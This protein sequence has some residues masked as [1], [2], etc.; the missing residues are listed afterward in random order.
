MLT[1]TSIEPASI[2]SHFT[3]KHGSDEHYIALSS[4][5][6]T[7]FQTDL[8]QL[9]TLYKKTLSER[10]LSEHTQIFSRLF[11]SDIANQTQALET[12]GL[13]KLLRKGACAIVQQKP[14]Q[15]GHVSLLSY[16][17]T[18][19]DK[20]PNKVLLHPDKEG[21]QNALLLKGNDYEM[22]W[23]ADHCGSGVFDSAKQTEN[24]LISLDG[25]I[26]ENQMTMFSNLIRTW[27][28]V[29]DIDN[30]YAGM[31]SARKEFYKGKGLTDT[32]H[33][34]ASTGIEGAHSNS[35]S[36]VSL[37][38]LSIKGLKDE[39]IVKMEALQNL[40]PTIKYG[41]TFERGIKVA[42]GDREH[43][44]ISGTASID[45]NGTLLHPGNLKKQTERTLDNI[46]A[47][48]E[49][50]KSGLADIAYMI[51][52]VRDAHAKQQVLEIIDTALPHKPAFILV[53][54]P[55]CRPGW[56]VEFECVAI[57]EAENP[58]PHFL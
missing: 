52:Y 43:L 20:N 18:K 36:L 17:I 32:T 54:A 55:V 49:P 26:N 38:S 22:L 15:G 47:L 57:K 27:V 44:Y 12:S 45:K 4:T 16:H 53:D 28:F 3:T 14:L 56:L 6:H 40:S 48:L 34:P 9:E 46:R 31:V 41:V 25:L 19:G 39:Q 35:Q 50:H 2:C 1:S 11:V 58:Y 51:G 21:I 23:T 30:H 29:R 8:N 37:D 13:V 33:Y 5:T 10:S 24:L 42:F 7:D